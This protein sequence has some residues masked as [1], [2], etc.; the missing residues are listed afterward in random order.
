MPATFV[1]VSNVQFLYNR[2]DAWKAQITLTA[3]PYSPATIASW[4]WG[5]AHYS[6]D[7]KGSDDLHAHQRGDD[8]WFST[9]GTFRGQSIADKAREMNEY[10]LGEPDP[11]AGKSKVTST[12]HNGSCAAGYGNQECIGLF[13]GDDTIDTSSTS[14]SI[15]KGGRPRTVPSGYCFGVPIPNRFCKFS[16]SMITIDHGTIP[17]GKD[18]TVETPINLRCLGSITYSLHTLSSGEHVSLSIDGKPIDGSW[19]T[20]P[21]G[22]QVVPLT[23]TIR[24]PRSGPFNETVIIRIAVE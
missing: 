17:A 7:L 12:I 3:V 18:H 16:S 8:F 11:V 24:T 10:W 19:T 2:C 14:N 23:S 20:R 6:I 13:V 4:D 9:H 5:H 15:P 22:L 21:D 1:T